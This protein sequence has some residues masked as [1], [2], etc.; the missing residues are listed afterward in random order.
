MLNVH[1]LR[2]LY[3]LHQRGTLAAVAQALNYTPSAVSQQLSL[4]EKETGAQLLERVGRT[5]RLTDRALALVTH[6]ETVLSTLEQAEAE[7]EASRDRVAGT[8]RVASFQTA[9]AVLAP[10]ALTM[11]SHQFPELRIQ[12][13]QREVTTAYEG[14]RNGEFDLIVGEEYPGIP[15]PVY[16][17]IDQAD[18]YFD[19]LVLLVPPEGPWSTPAQLADLAEA[20]WAVDPANM[21][22]GAWVRNICRDA[23]FEPIVQYE[24]TDPFLQAHLAT[25]G[26][27][28]SIV[29]AL[30]AS[31]YVDRTRMMGLPGRPQR[32]L[33]TAVRSGRSQLPAVRAFRRALTFI[34]ADMAPP[35]P[36]TRLDDAAVS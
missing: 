25:S 15:E 16:S 29:S 13:I 26:H 9:M 8:L 32:R 21:V 5:V 24:T 11:L 20:S 35:A 6:T 18:L 2:I 10:P 7:L 23:G 34:A 17:N 14:L 36:P 4:L 33:Y 3:E 12:L 27:A 31:N 30:I 22:T 1:R 19:D 28:V